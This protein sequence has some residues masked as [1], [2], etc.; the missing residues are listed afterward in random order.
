MIVSGI[1]ALLIDG[2][3]YAVDQEGKY[4]F[5]TEK[6]ESV[7]GARGRVGRK[8]MGNVPFVEAKVFFD[9]TQ[10]AQ[11]LAAVRGID[12]QLRCADRI[13]TLVEA[14]LVNSVEVDANDNSATVRFEGASGTEVFV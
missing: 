4:D 9:T 6:V 7:T 11:S 14:D 8:V 1:K 10:T 2:N 5:S 3:E 13:C 12:V